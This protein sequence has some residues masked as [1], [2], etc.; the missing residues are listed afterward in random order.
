MN[1]PSR[2]VSVSSIT[3]IVSTSVKCQ[4]NVG[5]VTPRQ[6]P[7][8]SVQQ[9]SWWL[10]ALPHGWPSERLKCSSRSTRKSP[11][12]VKNG[13]SIADRT[14]RQTTSANGHGQFNGC[15]T[16][17]S[18]SGVST[19]LHL[20]TSLPRDDDHDIHIHKR[21]ELFRGLGNH[22]FMTLV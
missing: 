1:F 7:I 18:C 20:C 12:L 3:G 11:R 19:D 16:M 14:N 21:L 15:F 6:E 13:S 22:Y 10:P 17:K 4:S 5:A 9:N 8:H 2:Q